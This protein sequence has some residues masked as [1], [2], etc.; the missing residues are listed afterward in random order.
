MPPDLT[1]YLRPV[2]L[3]PSHAEDGNARNSGGGV[4]NWRGAKVSAAAPKKWFLQFGGTTMAATVSDSRGSNY[5]GGVR[6]YV[7]EH[8]ANKPGYR[9]TGVRSG[10]YLQDLGA[11]KFCLCPEG[12]HPW[13]PRPVY[14]VLLGCIPVVVSDRQELPLSNLIDWD[15]FTVWIRPADIAGM[16]AVLRAISDA[17]VGA[18][19]LAMGRAWRALW[20]GTGG[21]GHQAVMV[22]LAARLS[23]VRHRLVFSTPQPGLGGG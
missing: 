9:I 15:A 2:Y 18:R 12:W 3:Q 23:P 13:S 20:Y 21:L 4:G 8:I 10:S 16:D 22:E 5:S 6:Q 17:E 1:H 19:Q 11:S 14:S 7:A